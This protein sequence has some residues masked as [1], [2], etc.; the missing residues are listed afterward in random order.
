[1]QGQVRF[2]ENGTRIHTT[3]YLYQ[4][5]FQRTLVVIQRYNKV[6]M[7]KS[8]EGLAFGVSTFMVKINSV[9]NHDNVG[10]LCC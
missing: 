8:Y 5:R 7:Y 1:M 4:Y 3:A 2:D 10:V 9:C 6:I